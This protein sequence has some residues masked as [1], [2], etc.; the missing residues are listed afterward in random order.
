MDEDEVIKFFLSF[1][2]TGMAWQLQGHNGR[3]AIP[4]N[5]ITTSY[6]YPFKK[7]N[8]A[9]YAYGTG[10]P[11]MAEGGQIIMGNSDDP[12][13]KRKNCGLLYWQYNK[14]TQRH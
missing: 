3:T 11:E 4:V 8:C 6:P 13:Q 14:K 5:V 10:N 1:I 7:E 12:E 2:D 9:T